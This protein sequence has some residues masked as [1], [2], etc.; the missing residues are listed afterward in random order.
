MGLR[1]AGITDTGT[2]GI[3]CWLICKQEENMIYYDREDQF[4]QQRLQKE[5]YVNI[6]IASYKEKM[7]NACGNTS[8]N[9]V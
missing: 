9:L 4:L 5:I 6:Q 7:G 2:V 3:Q 8:G 1:R